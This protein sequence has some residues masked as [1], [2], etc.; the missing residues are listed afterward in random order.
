MSVN[1]T[2]D[3]TVGVISFSNPPVNA[4]N[5][6]LRE[7]LLKAVLELS[8]DL[9]IHAII[10]WGGD[11]NFIA[12]ADISEMNLP[13]AP[14]FL[15]ELV[16][17]LDHSP[18]LVIAALSG[19]ALGG[20]CEIALACDLRL[21]APGA[22]IGLTETRLGLIP[23]AGGT[24]R[25][26]RL[27]GVSKAVEL[28]CSARI[29]R[30]QD[31][32]ALEL[33]DKLVAGD[34][35]VEAVDLAKKLVREGRASKR[36]TSSLV[37]Q[38]E[39]PEEFE[40]AVSKARKAAKGVK[41]IEDVIRVISAA[42]GDFKTGLAL[43]RE[44]FL[45]LRASPQAAALRYMF[46]AEREAGKLAILKGVEPQPVHRTAVIGAGTMG[47]GIT[48]ALLLSGLPVTL[49]ER[50]EDAA[51]KG[52][53][54]VRGLLTRAIESGR[55]QAEQ[56]ALTVS[57]DWSL[58]A[59]A[60]LIIEAAFEDLS[61]KQDIFKRLDEVAKPE[62]ILAT[63]TSYLDVAA[64]AT[65][66]PKTILGLHFFAP[67]Q[68]M[69]LL[70]IVHTP[71]TSPKA[72]A[73]ALALSKRLGKQPVIAGNQ[74]GFIGNRVY[75]CYRRHAEYLL[76]D[77]AFPHEVDAA[78]EAYG[79]A[80]GIFAVSDVSGLDIAYAMRR[81][82]DSTRNPAERYVKVPDLLVEMGRLGRKTKAGWYAYDDA[83]NR[84]RDKIVEEVILKARAERGI[85]PCDL[86][87]E[88]IQFRLLSVMANEGAKLLMEG[89]AQ[90][91][92]D[93]DVAFVNGYGFPR[94]KGGPMWAADEAGLTAVLNELKI[95][96]I[97]PAEILVELEENNRRLSDWRQ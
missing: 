22:S 24:Q 88:K 54:R 1:I 25:L 19:P 86:I 20:G 85:A 7:G 96:K 48:A 87:P 90:R 31:A 67:A 33:V 56:I 79:M 27:V 3:D 40:Q 21:A 41:A 92:S 58:V 23:G 44:A 68:V 32:L 55:I 89:V 57:T 94:T 83:G 97:V 14:P 84:A 5:G 81:R 93:V 50:D 15:P 78:M 12:G 69:K 36:R 62:A 63:N 49:I 29:L 28:I 39:S 6:A 30:V 13:P 73:T 4:L 82:Q 8:D 10:L 77:G 26:P 65:V 76:E 61:V 17:A 11:K 18:K 35:L 43:E 9:L 16:E 71:S 52:E 74:E 72:L 80:M 70:E 51:A 66:R 37:S 2:R 47:A 45:A 42:Q 34:L 91:A 59:Q 53:A 75:A 38:Q 64:I 60:D 46:F 95:A